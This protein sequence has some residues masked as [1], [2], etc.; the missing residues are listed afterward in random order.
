MNKPVQLNLTGGWEEIVNNVER[1]NMRARIEVKREKLKRTRLMRKAGM[2][3]MGAAAMALLDLV[4][5]LSSWV[6]IPAAI[7][8]IC[9]SCVLAGRLWE[10][11]R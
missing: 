11:G 6:A 10:V 7:G 4:G 8:L 1:H 2:L 9:A 3:A 5:L